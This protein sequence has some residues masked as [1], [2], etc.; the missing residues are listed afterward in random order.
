M[1]LIYLDK[2]DKIDQLMNEELISNY[3]IYNLKNLSIYNNTEIYGKNIN[4]T[5]I[6]KI[7]ENVK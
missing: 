5:T 4:D 2:A 1:E 3:L 6:D 7:M